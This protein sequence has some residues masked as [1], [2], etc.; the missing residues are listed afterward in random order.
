MHK[1]RRPFGAAWRLFLYSITDANFPSPAAL[2]K[3]H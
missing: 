3:L 2:G 1:S